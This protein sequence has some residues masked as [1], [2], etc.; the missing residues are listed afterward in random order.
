MKK[1]TFLLLLLS[2]F[3][4]RAQL[5]VDNSL[6]ASELVNDILL[7]EGVDAQNITINGLNA[8]TINAQ[9]GA[10][11]S[12]NSNIGI[13]N[14]VILATGGISV[15]ESPNDMPT[16]YVPVPEED[17]LTNEPDLAQIIS[18]AAMRDVATVEF[19]FTAQGDTL[20]FKYVF[21]SEEYNEHTCS[22]YN[23]VFGFFIS[24]PGIS[25]NP[26]Y[27]NSAKNI[28]TLP[29]S[30][31]PV[32]INTVNQ[33]FAGEYGSDFICDAANP[34]WQS[35]SVYF[36]NNESNTA[37]SATQFDGFTVPFTVE[38]PVICGETYHIK[39]AIADAIDDKN[40]SAVFLEAGSFASE[41]PL[42]ADAEILNPHSDGRAIEGCST[43]R[44]KLNRSDSTSSKTIYFETQGLENPESVLPGLPDSLIFASQDGYRVLDLDVETDFIF[45]GQREFTIRVLQPEVCSVDTAVINLEI[46]IVDFEEMMVD[47]PDTL[48]LNCIEPA[49]V[50][51]AVS[52]GMA[53]YEISWSDSALNGFSV[54]FPLDESATLS[55]TVSDQCEINSQAIEI[56]LYRETYEPLSVYV[57]SSLT[58]NCIEP[59][60]IQPIIAGGYGE[61]E[62][63]WLQDGEVLSEEMVFNQVIEPNGNLQFTVSDLCAQPVQSSI[64]INATTN[65]ITANLGSDTSGVC[66]DIFT[67]VP[68]VSGGFGDLEFLWKLNNNQVSS[69]ST[70]GFYPQETSLIE[71]TVTD[72][73]GQAASDDLMIYVDYQA[74]ATT[75]PKDTAICYRESLTLDPKVSGGVGELRYYWD[76]VEISSGIYTLMPSFDTSLD[77][78]VV[79]ACENRISHQ[80]DVDVREVLAAFEFNYDSTPIRIEN[81]STGNSLYQWSFPD[82]SSSDEIE[83]IGD[84]ARFQNGFTSLFVMNEIGCTAETKE[85]FTPPSEIF[86][87]NA[88]TPD[89]DGLND[90]F[91]AKGAF[92]KLFE[93]QVFDRWGNLV[94]QSTDINEGWNGSDPMKNDNYAHESLVY[95][96]T[97]RA[98]TVTGKVSSG[99][100]KVTV[101]R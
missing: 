43:I 49:T 23:D 61:Y 64:E 84:A 78:E 26:N 94:F 11:N 100:G 3:Q 82:G 76:G 41:P 99:K 52:G 70:Y 62:F 85:P 31:T 37:A 87:P 69:S 40:D 20:R 80:V 2:A 79:D 51:V 75:L 96:Y 6:T 32:A 48:A 72:A 73:C 97:Y 47:Y 25:G 1:L 86:I 15:A 81:Y 36:V 38:V 89:G 8:E 14:G 12:E 101:I 71:L 90:V 4:C 39:L 34:Q 44:L 45:Q 29:G 66:T 22:S 21:A 92:V 68:E 59:V 67:L 17:E 5:S 65:P 24:G 98:E 10:F 60:S 33:G 28:A 9:F 35:N 56:Y 83:P 46:E 63:Q 77:L 91:K 55:A 30:N 53:P 58:F 27:Q 7:G 18:P 95:T 57:P 74:M 42:T 19:D 13:N 16:A 88:F 93:M 50:E 54:E